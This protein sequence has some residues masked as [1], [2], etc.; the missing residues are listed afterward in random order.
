MRL[1]LLQAEDSFRQ[2]VPAGDT[3]IRRP[4]PSAE[5]GEGAVA[6]CG[7]TARNSRVLLASSHAS[8]L[9]LDWSMP[10]DERQLVAAGV[11]AITLRDN[12]RLEFIRVVEHFCAH[13]RPY[14]IHSTAVIGPTDAQAV[15][16]DDSYSCQTLV[17]AL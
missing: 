15:G 10:F 8:L 9:I 17:G 16:G 4:A 7:M 1:F 13:P 6:F 5:A 2:F 11:R 14:G 3:F 12:A